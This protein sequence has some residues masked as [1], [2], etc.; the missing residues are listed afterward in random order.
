MYAHLEKVTS[1]R[2]YLM[3]LNILKCFG[4]LEEMLPRYYIDVSVIS[5]FKSSTTLVCCCREKVKQIQFVIMEYLHIYLRMR[6][7]MFVFIYIHK[8]NTI[9]MHTAIVCN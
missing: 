3:R 7:N 2:I 8:Q 9:V 6:E 4:I 5:M 1:M